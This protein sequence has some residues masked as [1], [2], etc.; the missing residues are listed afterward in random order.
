MSTLFDITE[1]DRRCYENELHDW[2]PQKMIDIHCHVWLKC[3]TNEAG[4]R[5][6]RTVTWPQLVAAENPIEDL[7]ESYRLMFPGKD[8]GALMFSLV[9]PGDDFDPLNAYVA[10]SARR[11]PQFTGLLFATPAWSAET[12][13][14][15]IIE[16]GFVGAK[17]YLNHSPAYLPM[18][19][20]RI[21]DFLPHHQLEVLDRHGWIVMLHIP[22]NGR[23]KDRVNLAQMLEIEQRYPNVKV[24]IAHVGRAY[25]DSDVGDAFE[26][27]A[28][29][30]KMIFDF[31]ANTNAN[32]F[33]QLIEAVGPKRIAFGSDLPIVRMRMRRIE[34]DGH[35]VNLVPP[36]IYGDLSDDKNMDTVSEA[37]AEQLTFFLYEEIKA[38]KQASEATGLSKA[39]V[40]DV[41]YHNAK[42][43]I[44]GA[45]SG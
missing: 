22:R 37:E 28:P 42:R 29:T 11:Y 12:F 27:L 31:S 16:G 21:F 30:E 41:F 8:V 23:L 6:A 4:D 40:E 39:D 36:G 32:V 14:R 19:E 44:E 7:A 34:R 24:I 2:L 9:R 20:I 10:E 43:L 26:V 15:K 45:R 3:L 18:E 17:V 25:C 13:E 5:F 33:R 35:Y 38:F 1:A